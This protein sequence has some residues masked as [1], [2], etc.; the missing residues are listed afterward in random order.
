MYGLKRLESKNKDVKMKRPGE[1]EMK[2][3]YFL[4]FILA[5]L[6]LPG[7]IPG[8]VMAAAG[9]GQ[10]L[11]S[12]AEEIEEGAIPLAELSS[13]GTS[14]IFYWR[15]FLLGILALAILGVGIWALM[16]SKSEKTKR[17]TANRQNEN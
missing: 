13:A 4:I 11:A 7:R 8:T 1:G 6:F 9:G 2:I 10:A 12:A 14:G 17:K 5:V 16:K 15:G 3:K